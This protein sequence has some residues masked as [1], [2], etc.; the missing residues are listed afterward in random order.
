MQPDKPRVN[1]SQALA[2]N[3]K[4]EQER[5]LQ[6]Q[7]LFKS[8]KVFYGTIAASLITSMFYILPAARMVAKDEEKKTKECEE[9]VNALD[10]FRLEVFRYAARKRIVDQEHIFPL[11]PDYI[12]LDNKYDALVRRFYLIMYETGFSP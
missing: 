7:M 1:V 12:E 2:E 11:T 5:F 3:F 8:G 10:K 6:A 9:F 4:L